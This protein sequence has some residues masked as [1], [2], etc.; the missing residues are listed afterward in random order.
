[1][2]ALTP[3]EISNFIEKLKIHNQKFS[4]QPIENYKL[5]I[6]PFKEDHRVFI[7]QFLNLTRFKFLAT[8]F[9]GWGLNP[10]TL[11][12]F[13][14]AV[15]RNVPFFLIEDGFIRS[16]YT[17]CANVDSKS[18][19]GIS[20]VV[21]TSG[22]YFDGQ[23][24]TDL[25]KLLNTYVVSP[26]EQEFAKQIIQKVVSNKI[27]KYNNQPLEVSL[28]SAA[29]KKV[30]IIDQSYGDMSLIRGGVTDKVFQDMVCDAVKE[31]PDAEILFKVHPDTLAKQ[32]ESGFINSIPK[33][34]K[35]LNSYAN[36]IAL[37]EQVDK[38]YVATSQM[39][40]EALLCGKEV[41]VYGLPFYAGWGLTIDKIKCDRRTRT[42][43]LYELFYIVYV[44][45]SHYIDPVDNSSSDINKAIDFIISSRSS[46][47]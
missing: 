41:H 30:L 24:S 43:N 6:G 29:K 35:L 11:Y 42:L 10:K 45:Y 25:E 19:S 18:K 38:V 39:G 13:N 4:L 3:V 23:I 36:P 5:Y 17:W 37:L 46:Q 12:L 8:A 27:S 32:E 22:F 15:K 21:D 14:H 26:E 7:R 31:N 33:E 20:F 44:V 40:F 47:L 1:M 9:V 34:V 2:S 16:V 28:P